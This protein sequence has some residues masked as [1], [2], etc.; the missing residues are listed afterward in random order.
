MQIAR[1]ILNLSHAVVIV[2]FSIYCHS[3]VVLHINSFHLERLLLLFLD[4][5]EQLKLQLFLRKHVKTIA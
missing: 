5:I 4:S 3:T 1:E 2:S